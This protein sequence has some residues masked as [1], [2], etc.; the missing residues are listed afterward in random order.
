[1]GETQFELLF[2]NT[3]RAGEHLPLTVDVF[4][5]GR[6][7]ANALVLDDPLISRRHL[8]IKKSGGTIIA[9]DTGSSHGTF[10]N[11][12]RI[13]GSVS[14][15]DGDILQLGDAKL[16]FA[17]VPPI[18][19][20]ERT[21]FVDAKES[22]LL[23][24]RPTEFAEVAAGSE[25][26]FMSQDK[27]GEDDQQDKTRI[28]GDGET[29][30]MDGAE[31]K[32][33]RAAAGPQTP[34]PRK[35]LVL[36]SVLS[37]LT[38]LTAA[39]FMF[40]GG[41]DGG[42][43]S[44]SVSHANEQYGLSVAAPAGWKR[45]AGSKG[46]VFGFE[47]A[48]SSDP[49]PARLDVYAD[50]NP[51]YRITGLRVGF[52]DYQETIAGRHAGMKLQG[53][54]IMAVNGLTT[55]FYAFS[56]QSEKGK[57]LFLLSGDKRICVEFS[58]PVQGY[59]ALEVSLN[60]AL[61]TLKLNES[62]EFVDFPPPTESM[63]RLAL[64]NKEHLVSMAK[65]DLEIGKELL[66]NRG[67]RPENLYMAKQ[68][69]ARCLTTAMA[70][71]ERQPFQAEAVAS[72]VDANRSF[73]EQLRDQKFRIILAEQKHDIEQAYWESVKLAQMIP[74]KTSA[75]HQFAASRIEFYSKK[76]E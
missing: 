6:S 53:Y 13:R 14:L 2:L 26:R 46:A 43:G 37:V 38:V 59:Q 41:G 23:D 20:E 72:L 50:R 66:K 65:R 62:Q 34:V 64:A 63:R 70:V 7:R 52:E 24:N 69:L 51:D 10:L 55:V 76:R 3:S 49:T 25:T 74:D 30:L 18:D 68:A 21:D 45:S 36:I 33:L 67:V 71:S 32:G 11:D 22:K 75:H 5:I 58:V 61:R 28:I 56:S 27:P 60:N 73:S 47:Y 29:R 35:K 39:I 9:E 12:K 1:M 48:F 42:G 4:E 31:L 44:V 19:E 15:K 40:K 16:K 57:G 8:L 17:V 54:K